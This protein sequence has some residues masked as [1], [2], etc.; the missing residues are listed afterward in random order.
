L[1]GSKVNICLVSLV[2]ITK[3]KGICDTITD[4]FYK[5]DCYI[6]LAGAYK[7]SS[8]CELVMNTSKLAQCN[9][10][11]TVEQTGG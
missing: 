7:N 11:S 10:A 5:D 2:P 1:A 8:Y 4:S 3:N 9:S 6:E